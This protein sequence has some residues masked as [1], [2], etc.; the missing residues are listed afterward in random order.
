MS[1]QP[2][3]FVILSLLLST[4]AVAASKPFGKAATERQ[5]SALDGKAPEDTGN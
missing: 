5:E 3:I 1:I 2:I 4:A